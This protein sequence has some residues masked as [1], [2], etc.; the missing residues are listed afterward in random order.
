MAWLDSDLILRLEEPKLLDCSEGGRARN[1]VFLTAAEV[2]G[3]RRMSCRVFGHLLQCE[4]DEVWRAKSQ[5]IA[6]C[7]EVCSH[8]SYDY[9]HKSKLFF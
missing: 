3:R 6:Y 4:Y 8:N 7:L 2:T 9:T 1:E 5:Y